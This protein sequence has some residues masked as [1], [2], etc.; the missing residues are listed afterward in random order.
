MSVSETNEQMLFVLQSLNNVQ[1]A[2]K[3]ILILAFTDYIC[4][5]F[6]IWRDVAWTR[7]VMEEKVP[8]DM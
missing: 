3:H 8:S 6:P 7:I 4:L 1:Y 2:E 5:K